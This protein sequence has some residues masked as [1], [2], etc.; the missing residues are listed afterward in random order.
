MFSDF[1]LHHI[2][3]PDQPGLRDEGGGERRFRTPTLRNIELT[4]PYMHS[5][6]V[7]GLDDVVEF[8][9]DREG[10]QLDPEVRDMDVEPRDEKDIESF[11]RSLTDDFDREIPP[12]VPSGLPPGGEIGE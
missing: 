9:D 7:G 8:Y 2:G 11:L 5:G 3:A 4:A 1:E 6:R 12:R 10:G